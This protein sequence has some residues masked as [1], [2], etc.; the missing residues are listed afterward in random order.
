MDKEKLKKIFPF[1]RSMI[2]GERRGRIRTPG[3]YGVT[4]LIA[5]DSQ[6]SKHRLKTMLEQA[7]CQILEADDGDGAINA[8]LNQSPDIIFMDIAMPQKNGFQA[9]REIRKN[10]STA[11]TPIIMVSAEQ[12]QTQEF[13]AQRLGANGF[14]E[15][16]YVR[17]AVF[18]LM[19]SL[20]H[21]EQTG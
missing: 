1:N 11:S 2:F 10:P 16:P 17:S 15:K 21:E 18:E 12:Q 7:G 13:W 14:L 8:A 6:S 9:T 20:F 3:G 19:D 5:D 4:A